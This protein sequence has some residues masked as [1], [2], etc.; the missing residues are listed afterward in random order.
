MIQHHNTGGQSTINGLF[1][2]RYLA[3]VVSL[4]VLFSVFYIFVSDHFLAQ[5]IQDH[6]LWVKV[7][8]AKGWLFIVITTALLYLLIR[9]FFNTLKAQEALLHERETLFR[10]FFNLPI[11]G[12]AIT[13]RDK[14]W[15]EVNDRTCEMLGY[16]REVLFQ[17]SW[18]ELTH[19]DDLAADVALFERMLRG[20]IDSYSIEKRFIRG[21]GQVV[22]VLL[23]GGCSQAADAQRDLFHVQLFDLTERKRAEEALIEAKQRAEHMAQAKSQFLANMSH[24]IRTPMSGIIGMAQLALRTDLDGPQ[25]NYVQKIV[26]SATALLGLLNDI[27][28]FSKIEANQLHIEQAGFELRPL[29]DQ[30]IHLVEIAA[31][32]KHLTLSVDVAPDLGRCFVGDSLRLTQVLTNLLG[33]A[34]KFTAAGT[35]SLS[36][37]QPAAGRLRFAVRDTGI[38]MNAELRQRLFQPFV[39]AD[40]GTTRQFGGTGLGLPISQRLVALMG[41][42]IE[43]TSAPGQGSCFSFEIAAPSDVTPDAGLVEGKAGSVAPEDG[44]DPTPLTELAGRHLLLVEDN[45]INREIV[46]GLLAGTGLTIEVAENG[47][48]AV[49]QCQQRSFDLILMDIQMPVMDGL[50]AS[51]RIRARDPEVPIVALTA[52]AFP[53]DIGHTLAAGMNAHLSKPIGLDQLHKVLRQY[54]QPMPERTAYAPPSSPTVPATA[55]LPTDDLPAIAGIDRVRVTQIFGH[56]RALF[57]RLLEG[58]AD[59]YA[60]VMGQTMCDLADGER[61]RAARR[62][63]SLRGSA[64]QLGA[65][66]LATVAGA[67]EVA[68]QQEASALDTPLAALGEQVNALIAAIASWHRG[69]AVDASPAAPASALPPL[70][71]TGL[72]ELRAALRTYNLKALRYYEALQPALR[73]VLGA[74]RTAAIGRAIRG[75][76][77]DEALAL[78]E[79]AGV[80]GDRAT[81]PEADGMTSE[82]RILIVDDDP[83]AILA[84][85][86]ALEGLGDVFFATSGA[87]A[88]VRVAEPPCDL[89]LLDVRMPGM[90]G[91]ETCQ[92]VHAD[93]PEMAIIFVTG[94][95]DSDI[96]VRALEAGARDFINKP[97]HPAVVDARVR[98]HL[99]LKRKARALKHSLAELQD[100]YAE[101][102]R[103]AGTDK[104][105]GAWNRRRLEETVA[106][107]QE[108]RRRHDLPLSL[109]ILD[110]DHFKRINDTYGHLAGDQVLAGLAATVQTG[111][112]ATDSLTRWG[113]EEFIILTPNAP[114]RSATRMAERLR[115][116]IAAAVFPSVGQITVS[117]GVAECL[118]GEDWEHWLGRADDALYRAKTQGRNQV[119][120][121][122]ERPDRGGPGEQVAVG[123][124][125]LNWRRAYACGHAVI[126][127]QHRGLF[128]DANGLLTAV[129]SA[130][131]TEEVASLVDK[132]MRDVVRHFA[133]EEAIVT[134]AGWPGATEHAAIHRG[135]VE[136]AGTL[137]S[138]FQAGTLG[139][140]EL[141]QFLAQ[142]LV[143]LHILRVDREFFPLLGED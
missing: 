128:D 5:A 138:H 27:L 64:G 90:G 86:G 81:R 137:V 87:D 91:F 96:E 88:L 38:G 17:K 112:R 97:I 63:H 115:E 111:L 33:N 13:S 71:P 60:D 80:A 143:A 124:V 47:Q 116:V 120:T 10:N 70:D 12:T 61:Q 8:I 35:V 66:E 40:S 9:R 127:R 114:L 69:A 75:L 140:G 68:I 39:Q 43:V 126:D 76:R 129:L 89:M 133:D 44:G 85:Y 11:V 113:G 2:H 92:A 130:R 30:V 105:T 34:V 104:L 83:L 36:V 22:P 135:L 37:Q 16:P 46:L 49:D 73:G 95:N 28:D 14:G 24:E 107:E 55:P 1:G 62:M 3:T 119:Q 101:L 29:I 51:R 79:D 21:D 108:R 99:E 82:P 100:A 26:T 7:S 123:F 4:Y 56:N 41:G 72:A 31:Q 59:E 109:M 118:P 57:L 78:L 74:A 45:A 121:A 53:D 18:A 42:T 98:L 131:P 125:R 132:L 19:P 134:T 136:K 20:E 93:H 23:T 139:I 6:P 15:I 65:L 103:L 141:F 54:L 110:I 94:D 50:E 102:E 52:N 106:N 77:V 142:D 117:I 84:L 122:P 67:L 32:D 58:F 48:Q 25:R